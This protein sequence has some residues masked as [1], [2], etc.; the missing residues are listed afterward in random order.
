MVHLLNHHLFSLELS[1]SSS[2]F[3]G[4]FA[5]LLSSYFV[6]FLFRQCLMLLYQAL[7]LNHLLLGQHL[8]CIGK[9]TQTNILNQSKFTML[10]DLVSWCMFSCMFSSDIN[11]RNCP[12]NKK[13]AN[14]QEYNSFLTSLFCLPSGEGFSLTR[15]TEFVFSNLLPI[16]NKTKLQVLCRQKNQTTKTRGLASIA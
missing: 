14:D 5:T 3:S 15:T 16:L 10:R 12:Y 1:P 8:L 2:S 6:I 13:E 9:F 4:L 11:P 7:L